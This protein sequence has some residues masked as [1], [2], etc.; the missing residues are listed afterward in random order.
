M[1]LLLRIGLLVQRAAIVRHNRHMLVERQCR[2]QDSVDRFKTAR[3]RVKK[4]PL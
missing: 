2:S 4:G 3:S 1:A